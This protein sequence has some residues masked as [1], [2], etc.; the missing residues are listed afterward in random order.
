MNIEKHIRSELCKLSSSSLML[1]FIKFAAAVPAL[2]EQHK[3]AT[4][5]EKKK[6]LCKY[7]LMRDSINASRAL[8]M[9]REGGAV[10]ACPPTYYRAIYSSYW[11][12]CA[13]SFFRYESGKVEAREC[14]G[15]IL[16]LLHNEIKDLE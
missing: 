11:M 7:I 8:L 14:F 12:S 4:E 6:L 16:S 2:I 3:L 1:L 15:Y 9:E 10:L 5:E 13:A